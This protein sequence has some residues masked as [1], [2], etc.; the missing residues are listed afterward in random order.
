MS[1]LLNLVG[2]STGVVLYAMLLAMVRAREARSRRRRASI[3]CSSPP[4]CSA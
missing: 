4:R 1:E 2:L 3:R